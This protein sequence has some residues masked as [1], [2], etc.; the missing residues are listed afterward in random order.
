MRD[1]NN[2]EELGVIEG[3]A[4]RELFSDESG[5][6][7][8][9][10][11]RESVSGNEVRIAGTLQGGLSGR[12][13]VCNGKWQENERH[14]RQF[15]VSSYQAEIPTSSEGLKAFFAGGLFPGIGK[16]RAS[17]LIRLRIHHKSYCPLKVSEK[18]NCSK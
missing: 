6:F 4:L 7:A 9:Y 16:K 1:R 13:L 11:L 2:A 17:E 10:V 8:V 5:E 12:Q 18:I 15:R 3:L 14:G